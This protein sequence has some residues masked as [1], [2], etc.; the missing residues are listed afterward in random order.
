MTA[1]SPADHTSQT[2]R[3]AVRMVGVS[4]SY[5]SGTDTV[6]ALDGISLA[7]TPGSFTAVMGPS[8][9]GK[10]TLLMCAAGLETPDA[11]RI[12]IGD[13]D[14]VGLSRHALTRFR[15]KHIG[16]VFQAYNLIDHLTVLENIRLPLLLSG[17]RPDPTWERWLIESVDLQDL[18]HRLPAQL[19]GGQAQRVAIVRALITRPDVVLADEP[20]GALDS[21]TGGEV[22]RVFRETAAAT[23]QTVVLVTHDAHI[24][25]AAGQVVF[26]ADGRGAGH[27]VAPTPTEVT[28]RVM[29]L[30]R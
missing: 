10:S 21:H 18:M 17:S 1:T 4:K 26:I 30:R 16:V 14:M 25:S 8:G 2:T 24:A 7:L 15:R 9:S 20:T 3:T 19:S 23:G 6:R 13:V 11:G 29:E 28:A 12:I 22:L 27:L 5:T